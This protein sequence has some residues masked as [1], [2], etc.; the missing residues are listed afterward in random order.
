MIPE[1]SIIYSVYN[2]ETSL[3]RHFSQW[4]EWPESLL[5]NIQFIIVDDFS[6]NPVHFDGPN[7]TNHLVLRIDDDID[8]NQPGGRNLGARLAC[9]PWLLM[10]DA[11][12]EIKLEDCSKLIEMNKNPN[13]FFTFKRKYPDG[14]LENPHPNSFLIS[15]E[16]FWAFGGYDEDFC[17][18]YGYDDILMKRL[19][20]KKMVKRS[21]DE[22][23][24]T[25]YKSE[26]CTI[27][28]RSHKRNKRLLKKK[29]SLLE[30]NKY[31][32]G[33]ILRFRWHIASFS[34]ISPVTYA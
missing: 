6:D 24:L 30:K 20:E 18:H 16:Q 32:N 4:R 3:K 29:S 33:T 8:W 26:A 14:T 21:I 13:E 11:D 10:T 17:G 19:F 12:H 31:H 7:S 15:R 25:A 22:I 9:A 34:F 23:F 5:N 2:A 27:L 28:D 1:L